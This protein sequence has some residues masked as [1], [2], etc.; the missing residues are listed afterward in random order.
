MFALPPVTD[1]AGGGEE[2]VRDDW[3]V[4]ANAVAAAGEIGVIAYDQSGISTIE[5]QQRWRDHALSPHSAA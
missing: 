2:R 1:A 3:K 5:V 4:G